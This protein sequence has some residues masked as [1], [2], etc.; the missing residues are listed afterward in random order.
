MIPIVKSAFPPSNTEAI[1]IALGTKPLVMMVFG[2]DG[3]EA[4]S[5]PS[6]I[7]TEVQGLAEAIATAQ[8]EIEALDAAVVKSANLA[9]LDGKKLNEGGNINLAEVYLKL[10]DAKSLYVPLEGYVASENNFTAE[11]KEKL[12]GI[13]E[14][15]NK[16]VVDSA[17]N[18]TSTNPVQN[19][20]INEALTTAASTAASALK[21]HVDNTKVHVPTDGLVGQV[22]MSNGDGSSSWANAEL[23]DLLSYGIE[24]DHTTGSNPN[25]TRIGN[26]LLHKSLPIQNALR[27]CTF[28][29]GKINYYLNADNWAYMEDGTTP[30]VLDGSEGTVRVDTGAK[31]YGK[32]WVNGTKHQVRI[33]TV[34]IDSTWTEIPRMVI[35]A[36][37][38]TVDT[39]DASTPK[40]V[41]VVNTTAAFRG[42][43]NN[44]DRDAYIDTDP[45]RTDLGKPRTNIS[46]ATMRT[47]AKNAGSDMLCYQWYKWVLYWLPV[48]EYATFNMQQAFNATPTAEGYKQGGLG[49]GVTTMSNWEKYNGYYPLTPCGY[50]NSLGNHTGVVSFTI[51]ATTGLDGTTA[52]AEQTLAIARW[53]GIENI[54]GDVWTNLDGIILQ[55]DVESDD[56]SG[57]YLYK[58]VY[59]STDPEQFADA[60]NDSYKI[61]GREINTDGYTGEFDLGSDAEIIPL[62]MGGDSTKKKCDYHWTGTKTDTSLRTLRVG[63]TARNGAKA[64][65]GSFYSA[66]GVGS[67]GAD[68]GFRT[69][70]IIE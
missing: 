55:N 24:W 17:I 59:V 32:S 48:I 4:V 23:V 62:V 29:D 42:G 12:N 39:T 2:P 58:N 45:F 30:S 31:F 11:M 34:Q 61:V 37:R 65:L 14:G 38:S 27:G 64:G 60:L 70:N 6:A 7:T 51:P 66:Y 35:D 25:C 9:T 15:A 50:A 52:I 57:N 41:S 36:Y 19:K 5:D 67:A 26:P 22:L 28:K 40:A 1:W 10:E 16:T 13:E 33:S 54:F 47:Y 43:N 68:I 69:S 21:A 18:G 49:A 20:V 3:W 63:G 56:G 46:R 44:A 8:Q 53:R